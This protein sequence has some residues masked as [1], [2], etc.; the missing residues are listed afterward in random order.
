MNVSLIFKNF[1]QLTSVSMWETFF[2]RNFLC[3]FMGMFMN[4]LTLFDK[5]M[6]RQYFVSSSRPPV[7][8]P[9]L[10]I[11]EVLLQTEAR[12]VCL[13]FY[14][15]KSDFHYCREN[16]IRNCCFHASHGLS[17]VVT[18]RQIEYGTPTGETVLFEYQITQLHNK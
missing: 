9:S 15:F 5:T 8:P 2:L 10:Y 6:G 17:K 13:V 11:L 18:C 14:C 16:S 4:E 7:S 1:V 3:V 12:G